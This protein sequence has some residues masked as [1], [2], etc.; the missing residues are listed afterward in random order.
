MYKLLWM[1]IY[2]FR[3]WPRNSND[4]RRWHDNSDD[5][6]RW[7]DNSDD[8]RKWP[9][10]ADDFRRWPDNSDE[11]RRWPD[12]SDDDDVIIKQ[13]STQLVCD[14]NF[15]WASF[16]ILTR[17]HD[18]VMQSGTFFFIVNNWWL[19][20]TATEVA[21]DFT[22]RVHIRGMLFTVSMTFPWLTGW[23]GCVI[24]A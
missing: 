1:T 3:R 12:N 10:N 15:P 6:R 22:P 21:R 7:P 20:T 13:F 17:L 23:F 18:N 19:L 11:F 8:F 24:S 16:L 2:D 9:N 14:K 4:F 5:S